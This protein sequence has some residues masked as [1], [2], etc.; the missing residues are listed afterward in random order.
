MI[1]FTTGIRQSLCEQTTKNS[2][3][4]SFGKTLEQN[5]NGLKLGVWSKQHYKNMKKSSSSNSITHIEPISPHIVEFEIR[6]R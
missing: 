1:D 6:Q 3:T 4:T 5:A 2:E